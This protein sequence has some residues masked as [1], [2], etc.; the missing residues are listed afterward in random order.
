MTTNSNVQSPARPGQI[1]LLLRQW[2]QGNSTAMDQIFSAVYQELKRSARRYLVLESKGHT[3]SPTALIHE[4]YIRLAET[5]R[6]HFENRAQFFWF[7]GQMMRRILVEHARAKLRVK[8]GAGE[9]KITLD[10]AV[11]VAGTRDLDHATLL[12]LDNALTRLED[13]D[14]RLSQCVE[15]RFFAGLNN[16]EIAALLDVSRT[17]VKRDWRLA[18]LLLAREMAAI[19]KSEAKGGAERTPQDGTFGRP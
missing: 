19:S 15:L 12:A 9:P 16:G 5:T 17:T 6:L 3:L 7:A 1:T 4:V 13:I 18:K 11:P 14:P 2:N 10:D 8:R